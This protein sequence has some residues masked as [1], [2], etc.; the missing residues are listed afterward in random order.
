MPCDNILLT[1]NFFFSTFDKNC[2]FKLKLRVTKDGQQLEVTEYKHEHNHITHENIYSKLP[3]QR[4]LDSE[5]LEK[6]KF[7]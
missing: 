2:P 3:R 1:C 4:R 5:D 6:L 7:F